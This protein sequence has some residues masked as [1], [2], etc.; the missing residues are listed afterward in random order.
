MTFS[1][2]LLLV[3]LS[4]FALAACSSDQA[5]T[6]STKD[7]IVIQNKGAPMVEKA[8]KEAVTTLEATADA[9]IVEVKT[10]MT[11]KVASTDMDAKKEMIKEVAPQEETVE[12][13]FE[14]EVLEPASKHRRNGFNKNA[15]NKNAF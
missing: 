8:E 2:S 14:R 5:V 1:K 11:E 6:S 15:A 13:Y 7:D 4:T 9:K 3:G 12:K 10:E